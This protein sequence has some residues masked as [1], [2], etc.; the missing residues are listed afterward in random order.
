MLFLFNVILFFVLIFYLR[1]YKDHIKKIAVILIYF[2]ILIGY[3]NIPVSISEDYFLSSD[4]RLELKSYD[5]VE[6]IKEDSLAL[7]EALQDVKM[8]RRKNPMQWQGDLTIITLFDQNS[9]YKGELMLN[10]GQLFWNSY[11]DYYKLKDASEVIALIKTFQNDYPEQLRLNR[12]REAFDLSIAYQRGDSEYDTYAFELD[13]VKEDYKVNYGYHVVKTREGTST[14]SISFEPYTVVHKGTITLK[15]DQDLSKVFLYVQGEC[16]VDG[17]N[18]FFEV[19]YNF[20]E[21]LVTD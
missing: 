2:L 8:V 5:R 6:L 14:G 9:G 4:Y 21:H 3:F 20:H 12:D 11:K 16:K 7:L 17:E 18:Q 1:D 10:K 19:G 13:T 15:R